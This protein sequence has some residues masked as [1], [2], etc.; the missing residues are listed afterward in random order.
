MFCKSVL[1]VMFVL[2]ISFLLGSGGSNGGTSWK[3]ITDE[4]LLINMSVI[5]NSGKIIRMVSCW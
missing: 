3:D 4:V 2:I 5:F 1:I